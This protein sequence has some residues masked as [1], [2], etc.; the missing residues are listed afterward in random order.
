M[1]KIFSSLFLICLVVFALVSAFFVRIVPVYNSE[2][3]ENIVLKNA[4]NNFKFAFSSPK[5]SLFLGFDKEKIEENFSELDNFCVQF[6]LSEKNFYECLDV[7]HSDETGQYYTFPIVTTPT[8][9]VAFEIFYKNQKVDWNDVVLYS[10]NTLPVGKKLVFENISA[11]APVVSRADWGADETLRYKSHPRQI[12]AA[13]ARKLAAEKVKI[14][15]AA[16]MAAAKK[17]AD[18]NSFIN[19]HLDGFK[20]VERITHENGHELLWPIQR[21]NKVN[22]IVIHHTADKINGR[23]DTELLRAIYSYHAVTRGWGDIGYN[24]IVGQNGTIYEGRAG[25]DYV[26]GAHASY[27]NIGS[28]GISVLGTYDKT[29][30]NS[31]QENGMK[32]AIDM[33]VKKYNIDLNATVKGFYPCSVASCYPIKLV[34]TKALL[35]HRDVG[36]T[37]CP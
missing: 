23:S 20:T 2:I 37:S 7:E 35:G 33:V 5:N 29:S 31:A 4:E 9:E 3:S 17:T 15:S 18:I 6:S 30:L 24:Y 25:G 1:K 27:N 22:K 13:N 19:S 21:M 12:A 36:V 28:V 16:Q 32:S 10:M 11:N 34:Y 26:V 14:S 8:R